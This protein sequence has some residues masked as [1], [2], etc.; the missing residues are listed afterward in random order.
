MNN[1]EH[2]KC[3]LCGA[4]DEK[5]LFNTATVRVVRCRRC[6]LT[7]INPR[8][9]MENILTTFVYSGIG[10]EQNYD[11]INISKDKIYRS[12]LKKISSR[13][14]IAD[15]RLPRLLDIGCSNGYFLQLARSRGFDVYGVEPSKLAVSLARKSLGTQNDSLGR[16]RV[17]EGTLK[18]ANFPSEY[19]DVITLWDMFEQV[20]DPSGEIDEIKRILKP[21][22]LILIRVRNMSFHLIVYRFQKYIGFLV[23]S[24]AIMHLYGFTPVTLKKMLIKAGFR[25]ICMRDSPL[26]KGDPYMQSKTTVWLMDILKK[27]L[28][29]LCKI[30]YLVTLR[31]IILT[32]SLFAYARKK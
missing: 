10:S 19:F 30:V 23:T 24:P 9:P 32:P 2:I 27:M 1:L 7:Y 31:R 21:G 15:Y 17:F 13:L 12:A 5:L 11:K 16:D 14:P 26:T 29:V 4:E 18:Q 28:F 25:G 20:S 22:G 6:G 8:P 3:N